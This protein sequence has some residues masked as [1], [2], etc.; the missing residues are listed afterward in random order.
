MENIKFTLLIAAMLFVLALFACSNDVT[1]IEED[2][3][4]LDENGSKSS[5]SSIAEKEQSSSSSKDKLSSATKNSSSSQKPPESSSS[6]I[7]GECSDNF[8]I[9][10]PQ[11]KWDT[12]FCY[13]DEA[14]PFCNFC[15]NDIYCKATNLQKYNPNIYECKPS[16]GAKGIYLKEP[17]HYEGEDYEA[18]LIGTQTWLARNLNVAIEG[19]KCYG[20]NSP[21]FTE[22]QAKENCDIFG[23]LYDWATAMDI[24]EKYNTEKCPPTVCKTQKHQGICP[25]GWHIPTTSEWDTLAEF[26]GNIATNLISWAF[27]IDAYG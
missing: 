4:W 17:V 20:E 15:Y 22:M 27:G 25:A 11:N 13:N 26:T 7:E 23:R 1:G 8:I 16:V 9:S 18:V 12:H 2:D 3:F 6:K 19:S 10:M 5:S 21:N 24:D 14:I